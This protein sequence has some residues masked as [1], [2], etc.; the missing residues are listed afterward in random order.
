MRGNARCGPRLRWPGCARHEP[1]RRS[2][3]PLSRCRPAAMFAV[4]RR[5]APTWRFRPFRRHRPHP[6][7]TPGRCA[8]V[9][10]AAASRRAFRAS[11]RRV[12][13][14]TTPAPGAVDPVVRATRAVAR[15]SCV[16]AKVMPWS[17][18]ASRA[19]SIPATMRNRAVWCRRAAAR[20]RVFPAS[21][22]SVSAAS[23]IRCR[24]AYP[25]V[26]AT[27][28]ADPPSTA[29]AAMHRRSACVARASR[30][31]ARLESHSPGQVNVSASPSLLQ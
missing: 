1:T 25:A 12:T 16:C 6:T 17:V 8:P 7:A 27:R 11:A 29:C 30:T 10:S 13:T 2:S 19:C 28:T 21:A 3:S 15:A 22:P 31:D 20:P 14:V 9:R 5:A 18:G 4:R 26:R 23:T 24:T